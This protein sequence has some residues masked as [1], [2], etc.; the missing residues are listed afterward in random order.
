[1]KKII[2]FILMFLSIL[3]FSQTKQEL[4]QELDNFFAKEQVSIEEFIKK[5]DSGLS[6]NL[7]DDTLIIYNTFSKTS[8]ERSLEVS[9]LLNFIEFYTEDY[10]IQAKDLKVNFIIYSFN[11]NNVIV[12]TK[13]FLIKYFLT[14][15]R[16]RFELIGSLL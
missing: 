7:Q 14:N 12:I 6:F 8:Y 3:L 4:T 10:E 2:V 5:F 15:S 16:E 1:M 11:D 9:K 13:E